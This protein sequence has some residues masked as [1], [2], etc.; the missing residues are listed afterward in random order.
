M[1]D[2]AADKPADETQIIRRPERKRRPRRH[3]AAEMTADA[4]NDNMDDVQTETAD[5]EPKNDELTGFDSI[6][7]NESE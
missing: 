1:N 5:A 3:V 2:E 6:D 7:D 4:V